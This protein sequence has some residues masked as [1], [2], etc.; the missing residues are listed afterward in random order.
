V[1]QLIE[2]FDQTVPD[3]GTGKTA[4]PKWGWQGAPQA[5]CTLEQALDPAPLP[6]CAPLA[7]S[8]NCASQMTRALGFS[9]E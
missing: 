2:Y 1:V 9:M 8:P 7:K 5:V 3:A 4:L 6:T